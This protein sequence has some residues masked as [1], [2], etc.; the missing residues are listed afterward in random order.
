MTVS[1]KVKHVDRVGDIK[2][3]HTVHQYGE[4]NYV[5]FWFIESYLSGSWTFVEMEAWKF[6]LENVIRGL[7][8]FLHHRGRKSVVKHFASRLFSVDFHTS[9]SLPFLLL[10][11][12]VSFLCLC[13]LEGSVRSFSQSTE[14]T[15]FAAVFFTCTNAEMQL[16]LQ[17]AH[18]IVSFLQFPAVT[19]LL[20]WVFLYW[21]E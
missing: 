17:I 19:A 10:S 1:V 6:F 7:L 20:F 13:F 4:E 2:T 3:F 11:A 12:S 14:R 9:L 5:P 8:T 16:S 18:F 21:I 15:L